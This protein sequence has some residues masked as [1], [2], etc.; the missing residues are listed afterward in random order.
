MRRKLSKL[1]G[2][3]SAEFAVLNAVTYL[4]E[5]RGTT[6]KSIA[7]NMHVAATHV[8]A[9]ANKLEEA[10]WISKTQDPTD[11]RAVL[12]RLTPASKKRLRELT[13]L[14]CEINDRWF[15]GVSKSEFRAVRRFL[16]KAIAQ[17][18]V[19]FNKTRDWEAGKASRPA[20]R[21]KRTSPART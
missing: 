1:L 11:L 12:V 4:N 7:E 15:A 5:G 3:N 6:I 20:R 18:D 14:L 16:E 8:T 2:I 21:G 17:Y 10:G 13:P 19:A 9:T